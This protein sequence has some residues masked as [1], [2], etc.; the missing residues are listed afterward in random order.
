MRET[1][2][3]TRF[4]AGRKAGNSLLLAS[5]VIFLAFTG[6]DNPAGGGEPGPGNG[7][8]LTVESGN[9]SLSVRWSAGIPDPAVFAGSGE[10]IPPATAGTVAI[11]GDSAVISGLTNNTPYHVW[12][13][14][15]DGTLIKSGEKAVP[16]APPLL[17]A[18]YEADS[19]VYALEKNTLSKYE[20]DALVYAGLMVFVDSDGTTALKIAGRADLY[21]IKIT[22]DNG[23]W[24]FQESSIAPVIESGA[25]ANKAELS[26]ALG[27]ALETVMAGLLVSF[28]SN[29]ADVPA[30][31]A[32]I[33]V[34]SEGDAIGTLP[35][36]PTKKG[37]LFDGWNTQQD[38]SGS[39]FT[40]ESVV[41]NSLTVYAQWK[42][43][44]SVVK[45]ISGVPTG[46]ITDVEIDLSA[47]TV[48][49]ATAAGA[50][51]VWSITDPGST[52]VSAIVE[53]KF[54]PAHTGTI[55]LAASVADGLE[56][57][58]PYIQDFSILITAAF[59]PVTGIT[60]VPEELETGAE[61]DLGSARVVPEN[62]TNQ[63]VAWSLVD[64]GTT[65]LLDVSGGVFT[66]AAA[67]TLIIQARIPNGT[68]Q[69]SAYTREFTITVR[70]AFVPVDN[71]EGVPT[72]GIA[73]S[74]LNL[75]A[76][77]ATPENADNRTI[78]WSILEPNTTGARSNTDGVI[79]PARGG[80]LKLKATVADG[81]EAGVDYTK[82][83]TIAV[84]KS[85]NANLS[86]ISAGAATLS[87]ALNANRTEYDIF[88]DHDIASISLTIAAEDP[89]AVVEKTV[90][91][92]DLDV[93]ANPIVIEVTAEDGATTKTYTVTVT[94][95]PENTG[96][97]AFTSLADMS[98]ALA[99]LPANTPDSPYTVELSG[100][101]FNEMGGTFQ[102]PGNNTEYPDP[103]LE[104]Y[105][106][107]QGKYVNLDL[108]GIPAS[109]GAAVPDR[110]NTLSL[111]ATGVYAATLTAVTLPEWVTEIGDY[112]FYNFSSLRSINLS[113]GI[114]RIGRYAFSDTALDSV[115]QTPE[116]LV[117]L[118]DSSFRGCKQLAGVD[119]SAS[120]DLTA[121]GSDVFR[122]CEKLAAVTWPP[123]IETIGS[124]AFSGSGFLTL[125]LPATLKSVA[126]EA[127]SNCAGLL[128][129]KWPAS[130][131]GANITSSGI[132]RNCESLAKAELPAGLSSINHFAYCKNL[133][134][135][136]ALR[137]TA[138]LPG[139]T[140][141]HNADTN[142]TYIVYVPAATIDSWYKNPASAWA[143]FDSDRIVSIDE[144][145]DTP[146]KW[147]AVN[148]Q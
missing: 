40:A 35:E 46:G 25:I 27:E 19:V 64:P 73:D 13:Q 123:G 131:A 42:A 36:P 101:G 82:E 21:G 54:T 104:L 118:G 136:V 77:N 67:G 96:T 53:G 126:S 38:G 86:S 81:L 143:S 79:T 68:A 65:G 6:C 135:I 108:S 141:S 11:D 111:P 95:A 103:L 148:E 59:V 117:T 132:F 109:G 44:P 147:G 99:E 121:I 62:A 61:A 78:L 112:A 18:R 23:S 22:R 66:P 142:D 15:S 106:A 76:A 69:G 100:V 24:L 51:I 4:S 5:L 134:M 2:M 72:T 116:S 93:G 16:V 43:D 45:G 98:A 17:A 140:T 120:I 30:A 12:V 3:R 94:R 105:R 31:P 119:F 33:P 57:G 10:S 26:A 85:A 28:D 52:G 129:V 110:A 63:S 130:P 124:R 146:D 91:D 84:A 138:P 144:L 7:L 88:V 74:P 113:Q 41:F 14:G 49:P 145:E 127:F 55:Y 60:S 137:N 133:E 139:Y 9:A 58:K 50:A 71:I 8:S 1:K 56:P 125:V 48:I 20:A 87:P 75:G 29:G 107:L 128:W 122:D 37:V 83:F 80:A 97:H 39:T 114:S 115:L 89:D 90:W 32:E 34:A 102:R 92:K 70:N 47:A